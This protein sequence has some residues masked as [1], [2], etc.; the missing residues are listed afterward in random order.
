MDFQHRTYSIREDDLLLVTLILSR[1]TT[2]DIA[3]VISTTDV[4]TTGELCLLQCKYTKTTY[5]HL[6]KL[7]LLE[8]FANCTKN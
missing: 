8:H 2:I 5:G 3:V 7:L 1:P 6:C 4:D